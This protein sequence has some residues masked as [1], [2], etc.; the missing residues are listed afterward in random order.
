MVKSL[1]AGQETCRRC[2]F[3]PWVRKIPLEK[4]MATRSSIRAWRVPLTE[5]PGELQSMGSQRV[6]QDLA[7]K[8][9]RNSG[10]VTPVAYLPFPSLPVDKSIQEVSLWGVGLDWLYHRLPGCLG[11]FLC[12]SFKV[13]PLFSQPFS[14]LVA[15]CGGLEVATGSFRHSRREGCFCVPSPESGWL[16]DCSGP[17]VWLE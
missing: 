6:G 16:G 11:S 17:R 4:E 10:L 15:L 1:P 14:F 13:K 2:R 3:H 9:Q 5:E 8:Q 12:I 7:A